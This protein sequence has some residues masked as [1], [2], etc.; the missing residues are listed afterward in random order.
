MSWLQP[1][2]LTVG[3][4]VLTAV[5]LPPLVLALRNLRV[6]DVPGP[7]S[8]HHVPTPRGGGAALVAGISVVCLVGGVPVFLVA[9]A[10][11]FA[12]VGAIDDFYDVPARTRLLLQMAIAFGAAVGLWLAGYPLWPVAG[13][14]I[15]LLVVYVNTFNFMDGINGISGIHAAVMGVACVA[16]GL[17]DRNDVLVA[18]GAAVIG[19]G[20][21]FLPFNA[22]PARVFLGDVGSYGIGAVVALLLGI[23]SARFPLWAVVLVPSIYLIDVGFTLVS[24]MYRRRPL[25]EAHRDHVYQRLVAAGGS[26]LGVS[27]FVGA[28][29]ALAAAGAVTA[30]ASTDT[31]TRLASLL[32]VAFVIA[33]YLLAPW[34]RA[35]L[36][37]GSVGQHTPGR[38]A[39]REH[40]A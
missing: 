35:A 26:H 27:A 10:V 12:I 16:I 30:G 36:M 14:T 34:T 9:I 7:R 23:A 4:A 3:S 15:A 38:R 29:S 21:A 5:L 28:C 32:L 2:L 11:G 31:S 39:L 24:R 18:G 8:S 22:R 20:L 37:R 13:M 17:K 40:A 25:T 19:A 1:L 33:V 6:V